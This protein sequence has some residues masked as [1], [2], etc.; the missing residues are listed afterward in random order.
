M[1]THMN[2][3]IELHGVAAKLASFAGHQA[4]LLP[5]P[6]IGTQPPIAPQFGVTGFEIPLGVADGEGRES[7]ILRTAAKLRAA[8]SPQAEIEQ[9]VSEYNRAH[10]APPLDDATV[11]DRA[12]RYAVTS[13]DGSGS[14]QT[15]AASATTAPSPTDL[16]LA[17][18][19]VTLVGKEFKF[20]HALRKWRI[21]R[22]GRWQICARGEQVEGMKRCAPWL[23]AAA[24]REQSKDPDSQTGRRFQTLATRAQNERTISAALKL[25]ESDPAI[26][27]TAADFDQDPDL[28][29]VANGV[30]HLPTGQLLPHDPKLMLYQQTPVEYDDNAR[31]PEFRKFMIQVSCG[32]PD[33]ITYMQ[34]Q[35]G[36][37]LSGRVHEERM[38][39]WFGD[40]RNGKSV[41]ANVLHYIMGDYACVAPAAMF[42]TSRRDGGDAT[43]QLAMLPGKRMM[44]ANETEA[45]SRLSAQM[46]KVA[47]STEHISA[48]AL[49][50]NPFSFTPTHKVV[51]RG[52]HLPIIQESD[53]GTWRRIDLVPFDL[54]LTP[55]QCA[56][57]LERKL[58][59]EAAGILRWIVRGHAKWRQQGLAPAVR[60][61]NASNTYRKNSDVVANW[62][63][64]TFIIH[65]ITTA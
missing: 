46:L 63:I 26:A 55:S 58:R 57:D 23:L 3:R 31:S 16:A 52:N 35:L 24:A 8:G 49:H 15:D 62:L 19:F 60:V 12:R 2:G 22:G 18:V 34:R 50:G 17:R 59:A 14:G 11:L 20:D 21:Y 41:L 36:Y 42:M 53:E 28:F 32:D 25:A 51:M 39:F 43:P 5:L 33:W 45:G 54:K 10:V 40:G 13:T 29:N 64:E 44:L 30:I 27:C 47:V 48:R 38:F 9:F 61:R 6:E 4:K 7:T 1:T 65:D 37:V 56:P